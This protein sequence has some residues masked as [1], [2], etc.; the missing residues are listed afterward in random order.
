MK[1]LN[2]SVSF[3]YI[4]TDGSAYK[5]GISIDPDC[6]IKELQTGSAKNLKLL[7]TFKV[8]KKDVFALE[9]ECHNIAVKRFAKRGEWFHGATEFAIRLI[10]DSVTADHQLT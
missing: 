7:H 8:P 4:I 6:R 3:I 2:P 1:S 5:I 10:V 9:K